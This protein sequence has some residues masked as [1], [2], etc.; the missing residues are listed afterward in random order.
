ML[1]CVLN[2]KDPTLGL[3]CLV[4]ALPA[5]TT[6]LEGITAPSAKVRNDKLLEPVTKK[7]FEELSEFI[8]SPEDVLERI[9]VI[10]LRP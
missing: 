2:L 1:D 7:T 6:N 10:M 3:D 9:T 5:G 4:C 8:T